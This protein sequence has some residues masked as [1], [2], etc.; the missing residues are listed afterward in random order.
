MTATRHSSQPQSLQLLVIEDNDDDTCLIKTLISDFNIGCTVDVC[1]NLASGLDTLR[2][3]N[4]DVVLL[5]LGLPDSFGMDTLLAFRE[6]CSDV[7][8]VVLT[9]NDNFELGRHAVRNGAEDYLAKNELHPQ[10]LERAIAY[11]AERRTVI[12]Q[13]DEFIRSLIDD[14]HD[15]KSLDGLLTICAM[16]KKIRTDDGEW[17]QLEQYIGEQTNTKFSHG[18]CQ[19][20]VNEVLANFRG[21]LTDPQTT[22][23]SISK[24]SPIVLLVEDNP[25][26]AVYIEELLR[27]THKVV[28]TTTI[29]DANNQAA[30]EHFDV[31]LFDLGLPDS[32]GIETVQRIANLLP[33]TAKVVVSGDSDMDMALSA[34]RCGADDFLLKSQLD[35]N[36]FARSLLYASE[37]HRMNSRSTHT[38]QHEMAAT[39]SADMLQEIR[40]LV[41]AIT[42]SMAHEHALIHNSRRVD[43]LI[44]ACNRGTALVVEFLNKHRDRMICPTIIKMDHYVEE[45]VAML[46][47]MC[48]HALD[49]RMTQ[50]A[51][52]RCVLADK[53]DLEC[54]LLH[55]VANARDAVENSPT[56]QLKI[57]VDTVTTNTPLVCQDRRLPGGVYIQISVCNNGPGIAGYVIDQI[58]EA[59]VSTNVPV[60][61]AGL[62]LGIARDILS[63]MDGGIAIQ[64]SEY[65]ETKV[66][67][68]VPCTS[69]DLG[70][71][72]ARSTHIRAQHTGHANILLSD[73]N[74]AVCQSVARTLEAAGYSVVIS[75]TCSEAIEQSSSEDFDLLISEVFVDDGDGEQLA[76]KIRAL[77]PTIKVLLTSS[78]YESSHVQR[79]RQHEHFLS[80]P[81]CAEQLLV[82]ASLALR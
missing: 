81:F 67:C 9:G 15:T 50:E 68:Y 1:S 77:T 69:M 64:S 35:V 6:D 63:H 38:H 75:R 74:P 73:N 14:L 13:R 42:A 22:T 45:I 8:V 28:T 4:P 29:A 62:R 12:S 44:E 39:I 53:N 31:V 48:P 49:I 72:C 24:P 37:R 52:E 19:E 82:A 66:H 3:S 43:A 54:A 61:C 27:S 34:I 18:Y 16:C 56:P 23:S 57:T 59:G 76:A 70:T 47:T 80:K 10:R 20:C 30:H 79:I 51:A 46:R 65:E 58:F 11:A 5:D 25:D 40:G 21:E 33:H 41:N 36:S 55:V 71:L 26:D 7:P 60:R 17:K 32:R 78:F 2:T